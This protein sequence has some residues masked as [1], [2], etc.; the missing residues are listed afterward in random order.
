MKQVTISEKGQITLPADLRRQLAIGPQ[1]RLWVE[2]D[3]G[4]ILLRPA[5]DWRQ[6]EGRLAGRQRVC[7]DEE[8]IASGAAARSHRPSS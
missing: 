7:S 1:T 5:A 2:V 4:R 3:D 6:L 8:A